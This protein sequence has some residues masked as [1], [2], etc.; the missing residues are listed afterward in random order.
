[1]SEK[2]YQKWIILLLQSSQA[3]MAAFY[4]TYFTS[5]TS[6]VLKY[7]D[8][9]QVE[10]W[11]VSMTATIFLLLNFP[12]SLLSAYLVN[13][14]GLRKTIVFGSILSFIGA[15]MRFAGFRSGNE[16]YFWIG[17][18]GYVV[19]AVAPP[20]IVNTITQL[21]NTWFPAQQRTIATTLSSLLNVLGTGAS[22]G[23]SA[24]LAGDATYN[25]DLGMIGL[26]LLQALLSS[27]LLILVIAF[28]KDKKTTNIETSNSVSNEKGEIEE[29]TLLIQKPMSTVEQLKSLAKNIPFWLLLISFSTGIGS[30]NCFLTELNSLV[31]PK[32][33]LVTDVAYMG[34]SVIASGVLGC[35]IFGTIAECTKWFKTILTFCSLITMGCYVWFS[36]NLLSDRSEVTFIMAMCA[37]NIVGF[38]SVPTLPLILETATELTF[39]VAESYSSGL[40]LGIM[41]MTSAIFIFIAEALKTTHTN[42]I[43]HKTRVVS[44]QN[45]MWFLLSCYALSVI[46]LL[47]VKPN[48]KRMQHEKMK[49]ETSIN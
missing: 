2:S 11:K 28:F 23:I 12:A 19:G 10:G 35:F 1:M 43:N 37:V 46:C 25:N 13:R 22:F 29:S 3:F 40:M 30:L 8:M 27:I 33:Y 45:S 48:Y 38:C 41:S 16:M 5:I 18:S 14:W 47:L 34:V 9:R 42:P 6:S 36:I 20:F 39:P 44:M 7:Y 4:Q 26:L 24:A 49:N 31:M 32:N 15:W 21:S 17:F